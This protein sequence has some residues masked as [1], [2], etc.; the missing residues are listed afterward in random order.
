MLVHRKRDQAIDPVFRGEAGRQLTLVLRN[1]LRE[2][3]GE[4]DMESSVG[5]AREQ[6]N[7]NIETADQWVPAFAGMGWREIDA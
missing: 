7:E 6:R 3:G 5:F 4:P 1:A 2:I